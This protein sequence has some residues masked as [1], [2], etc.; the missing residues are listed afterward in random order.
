MKE[1]D[2]EG[3]RQK[4]RGE[5]DR[6]PRRLGRREEEYLVKDRGRVPG[7]GINGDGTVW[8]RKEKQVEVRLGVWDQEPRFRSALEGVEGPE[9]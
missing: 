8:G 1:G 5:R 7:G 2:F 6:S 4:T 3:Y 9:V